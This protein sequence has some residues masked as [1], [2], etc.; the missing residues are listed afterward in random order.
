MTLRAVTPRHLVTGLGLAVIGGAPLWLLATGRTEVTTSADAEASPVPVLAV[1]LPL[2]VGIALTRLVPPRL[3]TM[4]PA[5]A[6]ARAAIARQALGLAAIAVAFAVAA[7]LLGPGSVWYGPVK[8]ALLLGGAWWVVRAWPAPPPGGRE[9]RRA[10]PARWY[11][12]GPV[13]AVA[14][15]AWLAYYSPLAGPADLS[16]YRAYDPAVLV[17]AMV[18]TFLTASVLEEVFYRLLLQTRWEALYGHWPAITATALLYAAMHTHRLGDGPAGDTVAVVLMFNGGLG[19]FLGYL[20]SR[21]RNIW[22]IV[23]VHGAVNSLT[24]LPV[25]VG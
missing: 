2:A 1:L 5:P 12:P 3:P 22:A 4:R 15:W 14:A 25:L 21:Y 19:L 23:A 24:L 18:L 17:T 11:W 10:L 16:G 6:D 20:W 13:P 7:L 9:H 8:V